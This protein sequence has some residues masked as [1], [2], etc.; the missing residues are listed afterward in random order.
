M[1][2][3]GDIVEDMYELFKIQY[4]TDKEIIIVG[5]SRGAA[6]ARAFANM[7][8]DKARKHGEAPPAIQFLGLFDTV[9]MAVGLK[10]GIP[11]NVQY[12]A[13]ATARNERRHTFPLTKL[14]LRDPANSSGVTCVEKEFYGT[15]SDI[16]GGYKDNWISNAVLLWMWVQ[17]RKAGVTSVK[18]P[19]PEIT[20]DFKR[21]VEY[22]D[23]YFPWYEMIER[24]Y[25]RLQPPW[26]DSRWIIDRILPC[27]ERQVIE[28]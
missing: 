11:P 27:N 5:F 23:T 22:K 8:Y 12:V 19:G 16:G 18:W 4:K 26:H 24:S 9:K 3:S 17:M 20:A 1:R 21:Y 6:E 15:H 28:K 10:Q 2:A 7:I 14:F 25:E 13:H